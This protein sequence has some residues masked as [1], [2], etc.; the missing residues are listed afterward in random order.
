VTTHSP[1]PIP[2]SHLS[3]TKPTNRTS[4]PITTT[5]TSTSFL[6]GTYIIISNP[7]STYHI[8]PNVNPY[9]IQSI[10]QKPL[11][12]ENPPSSSHQHIQPQQHQPIQQFKPSQQPIQ[13]FQQQQVIPEQQ[14]QTPSHPQHIQPQSYVS[15]IQPNPSTYHDNATSTYQHPS[16]DYPIP[17]SNIPT[18]HQDHR[19]L[20]TDLSPPL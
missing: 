11:S 19:A 14:I 17:H 13:Q 9:P 1:S 5:T 10:S 15:F 3:I 20:L 8:S 18:H 12:Y 4:N 6:C 7:S 2:H 16:Q